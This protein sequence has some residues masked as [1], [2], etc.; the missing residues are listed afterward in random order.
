MMVCK[1][2]YFSKFPLLIFLKLYAWDCNKGVRYAA[3]MDN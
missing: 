3:G 2:L 1:I